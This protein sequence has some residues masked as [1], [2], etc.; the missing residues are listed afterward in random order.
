MS[1]KSSY[2]TKPK[3]YLATGIRCGMKKD[4]KPD[5]AFVVSERN[6][7]AAGMYTKNAV[8]GHSLRRT[9]RIIDQYGHCRGIMINT[10]SANAC[11]GIQGDTDAER[12]A[13]EA[14]AAIHV[15]PEEIL[16]CST[17]VI[18]QRLDVE[19]IIHGIANFETTLSRSEESAHQAMHAMMTTDTVPK[20][21]SET[22][23]LNGTPVTISGMAKGSG[24]IHPDLATMIA[25]FTTDADIEPGFLDALLHGA[26]ERTF[27]RVSVDGDTSVCDTVVIMANGMS[28]QKIVAGT[29]S[30]RLFEKAFRKIAEDLARMIAAD[31]EGATKLI[32][33]IVEGAPT[34]Q[35]A[36]LIVQSIC[37]SPLCKTAMF[38]QDANW[39]R[40]IT[41][42]GYSGANF[43]PNKTD[44]FFGPLQVCKN[45]C[46]MIFDESEAKGILSRDQILIK[47]ELHS[48]NSSDRMWT[49]DFSYDY[50]KI[51]G[52]YR[53]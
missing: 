48:G 11:I 45:G 40:I 49:C 21:S 25:V 37:R 18:G 35:D 17:G 1:E 44:I 10:V 19:K 28:G 14:A 3:G 31:G 53:S 24:M 43:D 8:Q 5:L 42:A 13:E 33:V 30:Q 38:G 34:D 4:G 26:V 29:D 32:E 9:R 22:I 16:T 47:L 23:D 46:A 7:S 39:G 51:N 12:I 41:A 50:V 27:N 6:A 15:R 36:L 52:S 20:E 2:I